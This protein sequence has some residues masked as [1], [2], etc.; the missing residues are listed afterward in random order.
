MLI[1]FLQFLLLLI[2]AI[3]AL[4]LAYLYFLLIAGRPTGRNT[5]T[6][7]FSSNRRFALAVP[8]HNEAEVI[9]ATVQRLRA[10]EYPAN[11]FDVHVVADYCTDATAEAAQAAG[12]E[13]HLRNEGPRGRKGYALDWLI[14]RLLEDPRQYQAIVIFDADSRVDSHFLSEASK[15]LTGNVQVIQGKHIISN[16]ET[17]L[18]TTLADADMRLNNRIRNQAKE[19]LGLSAPLMGDAMIFRREVLAQHPWM[20]AQ[21]LTEDRDYGI[22]LVT[23]G[24]RVRFAPAAISYGQ[25]AARWKDATPQRL[26]WYGGA[27]DLQRRYLPTLWRLAWRG[28][29]DALDKFLELA[30]PPFSMLALGSAAL[31]LLQILLALVIDWPIWLLVTSGLLVLAAIAYP[32]LGLVA[33][34]APARSYRAML[35]G[36]FY[37]IWRVGIG[38]WVRLRYRSLSWV[39]TRRSESD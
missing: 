23:Q 6:E 37:V 14:H 2:A 1:P 26:R 5:P 30:L 39:R 12:A 4:G 3:I 28:N 36:P 8:A 25:A 9:S 20:G 19:N 16:P 17:G 24:V 15:L 29:W 13:V 27:F 33:T 34:G 11:L 38:I 10:M 21:S 32:F 35:T 22:Y 7:P 18:F 31:F